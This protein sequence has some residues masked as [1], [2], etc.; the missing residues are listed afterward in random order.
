ML[1]AAV[2]LKGMD[3]GE[4][5]APVKLLGEREQEQLREILKELGE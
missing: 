2:N 5:V 4:T 1:K 3:V